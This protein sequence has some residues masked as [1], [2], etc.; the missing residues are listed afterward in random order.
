MRS[1]NFKK[2]RSTNNSRVQ[3][4]EKEV[5]EKSVL[6]DELRQEV[7]IIDEH[8]MEGLRRLQRSSSDTNVDRSLSG[9]QRSASSKS[10]SDGSLWGR[11]ATSSPAVKPVE[12]QKI[13]ET[14]RAAS[15]TALAIA[16]E[17]VPA[18]YTN[19]SIDTPVSPRANGTRRLPSFTS[20][21]IASSPDL[22]VHP[23]S[24]PHEGKDRALL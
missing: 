5:K 20:T 16:T 12:L 22:D 15:T 2:V 23:S 14:E 10:L 7:V 17:R 6:V 1:S 18:H 8:L 9:L 13:D 4:L 19:T 24:P 11:S 21:A 3:E